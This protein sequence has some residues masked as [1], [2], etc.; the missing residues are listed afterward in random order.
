MGAEHLLHRNSTSD[1]KD[2]WSALH[3]P[4]S[5]LL[6][7]PLQEVQNKKRA[8]AAEDDS[9]LWK[10]RETRGEGG[11]AAAEGKVFPG[12]LVCLDLPRERD[13][14]TDPAILREVKQ[15]IERRSDS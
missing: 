8:A 2:H 6:S 13:R 14:P 10:G 5:T 15:P 9:A 7:L 3:F 4:S 12:E 11:G 1:S